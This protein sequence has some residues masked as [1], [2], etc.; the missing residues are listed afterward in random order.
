MREGKDG[1][2]GRGKEKGRLLWVLEIEG[3][4]D[5]KKE[6]KQKRKR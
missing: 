2:R 4:E 5:G 3:E 1:K 6:I